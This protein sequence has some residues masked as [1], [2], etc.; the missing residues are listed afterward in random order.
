MADSVLE[1][2]VV[3]DVDLVRRPMAGQTKAG[4]EDLAEERCT[5]APLHATMETVMEVLEIGGHGM[6]EPFLLGYA[7]GRGTCSTSRS[8]I[9]DVTN[10]SLS[11]RRRFHV[12]RRQV[13]LPRKNGRDRLIAW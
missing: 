2:D 7:K 3:V 12:R 8:L 9:I 1:L 6:I 13:T 10:R 5:N 11:M 4:R